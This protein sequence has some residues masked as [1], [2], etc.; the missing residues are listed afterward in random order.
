HVAG[1]RFDW[2]TLII[3]LA[4]IASMVAWSGTATTLAVI[5]LYG[6]PIALFVVAKDFS[7][8]ALG[9]AL[10]GTRLVLLLLG[11]RIGFAMGIIGMLGL[12]LLLPRPQLPVIAARAWAGV[13]TFALTARATCV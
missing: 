6:A 5:A 9:A 12:L 8:G 13:N 10:I 11:V 7:I 3:A 4:V 2:G 1:R